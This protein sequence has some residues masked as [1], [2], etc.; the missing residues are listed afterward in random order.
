M[1]RAQTLVLLVFVPALASATVVAYTD[2]ASY[3]AAAPI[4]SSF[5]FTGGSADYATAAGLTV[6]GVN[7]VGTLEGIPSYY[8]LHTSLFGGVTSL[9]GS[10]SSFSPTPP[11]QYEYVGDTTVTFPNPVTSVSF[12]GVLDYSDFGSDTFDLTFSNG[13]T[14]HGSMPWTNPSPSQFIGFVS[15]VPFTSLIITPGTPPANSTDPFGYY[16]PVIDDVSYGPTPEPSTVAMLAIGAFAAVSWRRQCA[17]RARL[18][19]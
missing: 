6:D 1:L 5:G 7:F 16:T 12:L 11:N 9:V 2:Q 17:K 8:Y 18:A 4:Q 10:F 13:D 3:L 15:T 19:P 14:Y